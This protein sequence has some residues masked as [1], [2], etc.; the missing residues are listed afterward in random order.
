MLTYQSNKYQQRIAKSMIAGVQVSN[1]TS[2]AP[3]VYERP[4]II[5]DTVMPIAK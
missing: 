1:S 2:M 4:F 5:S 3:T